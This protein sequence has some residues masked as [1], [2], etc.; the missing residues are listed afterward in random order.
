MKTMNRLKSWLESSHSTAKYSAFIKV[1]GIRIPRKI[2]VLFRRA[3]A[4]EISHDD[5]RAEFKN[6]MGIKRG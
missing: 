6:E 1:A 2:G 3:A 5:L 4:G